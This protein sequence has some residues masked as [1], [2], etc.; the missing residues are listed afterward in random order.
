M[1]NFEFCEE[2]RVD[3][4]D[5]KAVEGRKYGI[6]ACALRAHP[7]SKRLARGKVASLGHEGAGDYSRRLGNPRYMGGCV[8][9]EGGSE[10]E[11]F[12]SGLRAR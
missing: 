6:G 12:D 9:A 2:Q 1:V 4:A 3:N 7:Q 11:S 10:G 5:G 8:T